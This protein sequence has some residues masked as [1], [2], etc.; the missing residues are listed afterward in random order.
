VRVTVRTAIYYGVL[1]AVMVPLMGN[2]EG[3]LEFA[4]A[5]GVGVTADEQGQIVAHHPFWDWI[6]VKNLTSRGMVSDTWYPTDGWWWWRASRVMHDKGLTGN[7]M[8]VISEFPA[9]SFLLGDMHPHVLAYPFVFLMIGLAFNLLLSDAAVP[10]AA[11]WWVYLC[12][13]A[14]GFLN[15]WDMPFYFFILVVAYGLNRY[16]RP[17]LDA[18]SLIGRVLERQETTPW[19]RQVIFRAVELGVVSVVLYLPYWIYSRPKAG[20]GILPN[21]FNVSRLAQLFLMFGTFF[22]ALLALLIVLFADLWKGQRVTRQSLTR[23]GLP[24]W[25]GTM[26]F[27]PALLALVLIP[28]TL[29][30]SIRTY[31]DDTLANPQVQQFLGPQTLTSLLGISLRIRLGLLPPQLRELRV[32]AGPWTFLILSLF[33]AAVI[34]WF[35]RTTFP[36]WFK[37]T[38]NDISPPLPSLHFAL[39][40]AFTG[41]MLI[42]SVEF[43]YLRD[44]FGTRMNTVFKFYFQAW[45]LLGLVAA[46]G[47]YYILEGR[48][49]A[50]EK[51]EKSGIG[52]LI[53]GS[54]MALLVCAGLLYPVGMSINRTGGFAGPATLDGM[55]FVARDRP[56]E[57][58]A[59]AWLNQNVP[60]NPV[61]VEAVRGSFAY[62][63]ARISSRTGLPAVMGW[64]GHE[65]QWHGL[66]DKIGEREGDVKLLYGGS[67]E[68]AQRLMT[69]YDV[70]YVVAGYL[71][72]ADF[73]NLDKFDRF[74]DVVFRQGNMVIYKR[75]ETVGK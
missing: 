36:R 53:V 74:M 8:E 21:L 39:L 64:T 15:T 14:I 71:E 18:P 70:S 4:H 42:F 37:S 29:S 52:Q 40:L 46:F 45:A 28:V 51:E 33:I 63:H 13:G 43:V 55:A 38:A 75:R 35:V 60:G 41:L 17:D 19:L 30:P 25:V 54:I 72:R 56:E 2:L 66:H 6:D 67:I 10:M 22:V 57:Y 20:A 68:D 3:L 59:V 49:D 34:F 48:T 26:V 58:A 5:N 47:L 27:F 44:A 73:Q 50:G 7:D 65:G 69:K 9:F 62:E 32:P 31:I 1:A 12:L 61:I 24:V 16:L 23:Q 11:W